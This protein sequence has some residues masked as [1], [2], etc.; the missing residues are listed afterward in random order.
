MRYIKLFE[1]YQLNE[2]ETQ[3]EMASK[4]GKKTISVKKDGDE[5]TFFTYEIV[6]N[7]VAQKMASRFSQEFPFLKEKMNEIS[8][9][10]VL[11]VRNSSNVFIARFL[12]D[13][14]P[15]QWEKGNK[16][17]RGWFVVDVVGE[18]SDRMDGH[19]GTLSKKEIDNLP[20]K[21]KK[22]LIDALNKLG[23]NVI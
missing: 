15:N 20:T 13:G 8:G 23:Y 19:Q 21:D 11:Y 6:N 2:A 22:G 1:N 10:E 9:A 12:D 18:F 4:S 5:V 3:S 16:M 14:I 17:F 7:S